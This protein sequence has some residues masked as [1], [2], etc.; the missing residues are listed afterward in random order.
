MTDIKKNGF[1]QCPYHIKDALCPANSFYSCQ[2]H[3]DHAL[4]KHILPPSSQ[5]TKVVVTGNWYPTFEAAYQ[6]YKE[7]KK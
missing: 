7:V 2:G 3:K 5:N 1:V 4:G 6:A